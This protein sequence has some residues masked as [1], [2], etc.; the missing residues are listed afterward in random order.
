MKRIDE[1]RSRCMLR[2]A[3]VLLVLPTLVWAHEDR[4][5]SHERDAQP[6]YN[7]PGWDPTEG[8][9]PPIAFPSSGIQLL[10]WI[11]IT[12]F[13]PAGTSAN[14]AWGYVAPSGREYAILGF[15]HGT[16][17]VEVTNPS[18]AQIGAVITGPT[19]LWRDIKVYQN[20]CYAVS[21]AGSGIQ[22]MNL[23][24][25]DSGIVTLVGTVTTPSG[26]TMSTHT[27]A[28]NEASGYLYRCGGGSF[29]GLR[30]YSLANPATPTYVT[31]WNAGRY[32]HEAQVVTYT[33][34]PYAGKEIA[35]CFSETSSGGGTPGINILDVTNKS[36]ILQ[37]SFVQYPNAAFSHQ[38]WLSPDHHYLF[39]DDELDESQFGIYSL[40]RVFDV[41]N[42][43]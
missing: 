39:L 23:S 2:C 40:T 6:P 29:I 36:N 31:T 37:L 34:G 24:Q 22:V 15:S 13:N 20:Y 9:G 8:G 4:Q 38:G 11:P 21:E 3:L 33:S 42:L 16:G 43:A 17:F 19:S 32:V 7:G 25:I 14:V 35:F 41:L 28:V 18:N 12:Q 26:T 30:I 27:V 10:S 5:H 1:N